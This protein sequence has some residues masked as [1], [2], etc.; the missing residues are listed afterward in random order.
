MLSLWIALG[1][2]SGP[3]CFILRG[4]VRGP[5]KLYMPPRLI[6]CAIEARGAVFPRES[7][8]S[9]GRPGPTGRSFS[10]LRRS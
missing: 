10:R 6:R 7:G 8:I 4:C 1:K 9:P 5:I 2:E 3:I